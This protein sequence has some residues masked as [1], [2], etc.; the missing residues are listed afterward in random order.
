MTQPY[1]VDLHIHIG[2]TETGRPVKITGSKNLTLAH[3]LEEASQRKGL[4]MIG[5][6]DCHVPEVLA[7]LNQLIRQGKAAP[8]QGGG[9]RYKQT[10]LIL[11]TEM[12]IYD[13]HCQG[14]IHVLCFLPT[15]EAMSTFSQWMSKHQKNITLSS[16]RSYVSVKELQVKVKELEGLFIPAHIFTPFKSV[17]GK[18]VKQS[19]IEILDPT[20]IDA[21]ELGLS[22]DSEMADQINELHQ[23]TYMT[24]S[25]A[26]SLAKIGREY[27]MMSLAK[28]DFD[29]LK[30]ALLGQNKQAIIANYGL[31]PKLGK[32]HQEVRLR[33]EHLQSIQQE[34][35]GEI[36]LRD[37][38]PYIHQVPLEYIPNL[39]PKNLQKLVKAFGS[40]MKVIHSTSREE[41]EQWIR[42]ELARIIIEARQGNIEIQTGGAGVYGKV[43][44]TRQP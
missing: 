34:P 32:Y 23:Y 38:P 20:L 1:F 26:H 4:D 16:Q 43:S 25:D 27:Q 19:L 21:V 10:T 7:E 41:L 42:P 37:R 18:G 28:P 14:P 35:R 30:Q 8:C 13:A 5:I 24:N 12:E 31:D 3:I 40:E 11:G 15:I 17:Y 6:I 9:V 2:R 44:Y 29:H 22:S 36:Q 33:L 39:G